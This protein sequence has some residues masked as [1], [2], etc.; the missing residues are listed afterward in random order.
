MSVERYPLRPPPA[1]LPREPFSAIYVL[2]PQYFATG[3][4]RFI[5]SASSGMGQT[6]KWLGWRGMSVLPPRADI[7]RSSACAMTGLC[8]PK[9]DLIRS[10]RRTASK[11]AGTESL[12]HPSRL[13]VDHR[14]A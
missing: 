1:H 14:Q 3:Q 10:P 5:G 7:V 11:A 6:R 13:K 9:V 8:D 2:R 4:Q 12:E